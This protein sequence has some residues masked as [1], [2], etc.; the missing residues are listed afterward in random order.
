MLF[1]LRPEAGNYGKSQGG[2]KDTARSLGRKRLGDLD[3]AKLLRG[4]M[5]VPIHMKGPALK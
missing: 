5:Y 4:I 3:A 2:T 1:E